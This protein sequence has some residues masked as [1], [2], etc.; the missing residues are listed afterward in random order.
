MW[1]PHVRSGSCFILVTHLDPIG[2]CFS[3]LIG[4][5]VSR[6]YSRAGVAPSQCVGFLGSQPN[7]RGV[8]GGLRALGGGGS[9]VF[10]P[11]AAPASAFCSWP[12]GGVLC[13]ALQTLPLFT[14]AA[15]LAVGE[16]QSLEHPRSPG[17]CKSR[18]QTPACTCAHT[19]AHLK[20]SWAPGLRLPH[21]HSQNRRFLDQDTE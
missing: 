16:A 6:H 8:Q 2:D 15:E 13:Q 12:P 1:V 19:H 9:S 14:P 21:V 3:A 7:V 18:L 10:L 11:C 17:S 20:L 4:W 5:V